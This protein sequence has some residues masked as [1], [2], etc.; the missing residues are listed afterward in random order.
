MTYLTFRNSF[1][2]WIILSGILL[3][4]CSNSFEKQELIG[5]WEVVNVNVT[6]KSLSTFEKDKLRRKMTGQIYEFLSNGEFLFGKGNKLEAAGGWNFD[7]KEQRMELK[8]DRG[9]VKRLRFGISVIDKN[10]MFW[11]FT[12]STEG[13]YIWE[14]ERTRE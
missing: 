6:N 14:L 5:H 10:H 2:L 7:Q 12:S 3:S 1:P 4:S 9:S 8:Y 11:S 13:G